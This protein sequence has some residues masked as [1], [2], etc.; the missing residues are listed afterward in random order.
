MMKRFCRIIVKYRT[1]IFVVSE[2]K[3]K[4]TESSESSADTTESRYHDFC[5]SERVI[6][7][8]LMLK[9]R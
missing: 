9:I 5:Y 1:Q 7:T 6:Q 4:E 2:E 3:E 8:R